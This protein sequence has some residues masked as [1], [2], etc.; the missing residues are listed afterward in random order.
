MAVRRRFFVSAVA[1]GA[2]V[3]GL[4]SAYGLQTLVHDRGDRHHE[5]KPRRYYVYQ[6]KGL[7]GAVTFE[8]VPD[9]GSGK[10]RKELRDSFEEAAKDWILGYKEARKRGEKFA[11]PKPR[12]PLYRLVKSFKTEKEAQDYAHQCQEKWDK[13]LEAK[14]E[15][16]GGVDLGP[17]KKE[18]MSKK[19]EPKKAKTVEMR[20]EK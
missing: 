13:M 5:R 19:A 15:K 11:D 16:E 20:P 12:K 14:R 10:W 17:V 8:V 3:C 1:L 18:G 4:Q 2:V 6:L 7:D 9:I